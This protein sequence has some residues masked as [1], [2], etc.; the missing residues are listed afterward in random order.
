MISRSCRNWK[1]DFLSDRAAAWQRSSCC[2]VICELNRIRCCVHDTDRCAMY[3]VAV[4]IIQ[5]G[6]WERQSSDVCCRTTDEQSL[7]LTMSVCCICVRSIVFVVEVGLAVSCDLNSVLCLSGAVT[8]RRYNAG[9]HKKLRRV[10]S[11]TSAKRLK[12]L[13]WFLA[14]FDAFW[15]WI[16][17]S[18]WNEMALLSARNYFSIKY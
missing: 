10:L 18:T 17:L 12:R 5:V 1:S 3:G 6:W 11:P 2:D 13:V 9:W 7:K 4:A 16:Q 14:N 8:F 15:S